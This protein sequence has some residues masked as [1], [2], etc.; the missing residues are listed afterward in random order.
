[1]KSK[2]AKIIAAAAALAVLAAAGLLFWRQ[3]SRRERY[4][5][6]WFD[7]FDTVTTVQGYAK[8][9]AAWNEQMEAL[10]A[11]LVHLHEL[12]DIYHHYDGLTNL[13]DVNAGA[14][15]TS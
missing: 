14:A 11:D 13:Y 15:L 1:M 6:T 3:S 4:S 5:A 12:F 9:E 8:S 2:R 10:H 7:V